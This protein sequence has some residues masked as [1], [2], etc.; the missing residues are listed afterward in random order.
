MPKFKINDNVI[1]TGKPER[2][3]I[4]QKVLPLDGGIIYYDVMFLDGQPGSY[5]EMQLADANIPRDPWSLFANNQHKGH[6]EFGLVTTYHKIKNTTNNTL[7]TL[8]A[9]RTDFKTFQYKPLIKFLNSNNRRILIAD[10]V[11]LGKTIEAGHIMLELAGRGEFKNAMIVCPKSLKDKWQIEMR[12]KFNFEF[13]II[14]SRKE[15]LNDFKHCR[16]TGEPFKGIVTYDNIRTDTDD[17]RDLIQEN[18]PFLI[19]LQKYGNFFD[20]LVCDEAHY[21]RN[22]NLRHRG[23]E[24]VIDASSACV[25]LTATPLMTGIENLYNILK[26]LDSEAFYREEQFQNAINLNKPFIRALNQLNNHESFGSVLKELQESQVVQ[27]LT[28]GEDYNVENSYSVENYFNDDPLFARVVN[29]LKTK[30]KTPTLVSKIQKD[31]TDMNSL[32]HIYTRSRKREVFTD[33]KIAERSPKTIVVDLT[34]PERDAYLKIIDEYS[35]EA[36]ALV[37]K[38]RAITSSIPA[39]YGTEDDLKAGIVNWKYTDSKYEHFK[40]I[41]DEV[42]RKSSNKLIVFATFRK[43]LLYLKWKLEEEGIKCVL[44]YGDTKNRQQLIDRF[45]TEKEIKVF[46]SSQVGT[47]GVDLQFCNAIVNYDL[48]WNPMVVEQR[49]GRIDRIGQKE[50][51]LHVYTLVLKGTIEQQ[52]HQRLLERIN[53]FKESV[54]DLESILAEEGTSLEKSI[55]GLEKDLY[56]TKLSVAQQKKK[57]KD[58]LVAVENQKRDL[59]EIKKELTDA[60]VNDIYFQNAINNIVN[61]QQYITENELLFAVRWIVR[62]ELSSILIH[63]LNDNIFELELPVGNKNI[64]QKFIQQN[65]DIEQNKELSSNYYRFVNRYK[66]NT[67]IRVTFNQS[68]ARSLPAIEY[69]N[70]YHPF[71]LAITNFVEKSKLH[72]NQ[73]FQYAVPETFVSETDYHISSGDYLMCTYKLIVEHQ[74]N[75]RQKRSEYLHPV[76]LD[77]NAEDDLRFLN[78]EEALFLHGRV[79][80]YSKEIEERLDFDQDMVDFVKPSFLKKL[81]EITRKREEEEQLKIESYKQ[82]EIKQVDAYYTNLISRYKTQILE[83]NEDD[84]VMP[85]FRQRLEKTIADYK[86]RKNNILQTN[87][88]IDNA[89]ISISYIQIY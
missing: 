66:D 80:Q 44:L 85:M 16:A 41:V 86:E 36:L 89:L 63:N 76:V 23:L 48:P 84:K 78:D 62:E 59:A 6:E 32:N 79:Q 25:F 18:N 26:L 39:F 57:I 1:R 14:E 71:I 47:E 22:P 8:R 53:V 88:Q 45:R 87:I 15:L 33:G 28:I 56:G 42:V 83:R 9:S 75:K 68:T 81:I 60:M 74:S 4:I 30:E 13:K 58:T 54:G 3:G 49:I 50:E 55:S 52:I 29:N 37:M 5:P 7:S 67:K 69:I 72:V 64:L 31:L 51:I 2:I 27:T 73:V 43:T 17:R 70:A 20:I 61:N 12:E 24:K 11:G 40:Q 38:K 35:D 46:L 77:A 19:E 34:E 10:E 21:V 65:I 82:R